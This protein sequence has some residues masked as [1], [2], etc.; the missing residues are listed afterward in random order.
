MGDWFHIKDK[1]P[2]NSNE[3]VIIYNK[4]VLSV[5]PRGTYSIGRYIK[6]GDGEFLWSTKNGTIPLGYYP[7]WT[8]LPN[9]PKVYKNTKTVHR[10]NKIMD[11]KS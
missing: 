10:P 7:Y 5:D 8:Y 3:Y 2:S 9:P 1:V 11:W 6:D 4:E